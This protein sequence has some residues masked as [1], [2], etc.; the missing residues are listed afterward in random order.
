MLRKT[1]VNDS[2]MKTIDNFHVEKFAF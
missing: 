1:F 2:K